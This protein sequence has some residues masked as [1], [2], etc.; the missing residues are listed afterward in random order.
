MT[1]ARPHLIRALVA[2]VPLIAGMVLASVGDINGDGSKVTLAVVGAVL[3]LLGGAA[4]VRSGSTALRKSMEAEGEAARGATLGL[5]AQAFGYVLV[6]LIVLDAV[7]VPLQGLLLGGA[8]T[9]VVIGLAAQQVL[10]NFF[11]GIVLALVRPFRVGQRV[12]LRSGPLGGEYEGTVTDMGLF[13]VRMTTVMG[14]VQLPN[15][16]VLAAAVGPGARARTEEELETE[17]KPSGPAQGGPPPPP[18]H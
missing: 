17:Q 3:V 1:A 2:C 18:T 14:D 6:L 5:I 4:A 12:V 9:G 16:G 11:A 13:Y 8:L 10:A 15:A 7:D